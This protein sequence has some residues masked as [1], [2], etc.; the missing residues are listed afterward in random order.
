MHDSRIIA[1]VGGIENV[2]GSNIATP[3]APPS[4]GRT[5]I[6]TP[7]VTPINMRSTLNGV[8]TTANPWNKALSSST[9]SSLD[10][11]QSPPTQPSSE[12]KEFMHE[13]DAELRDRPAVLRRLICL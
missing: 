6:R 10:P 2:S 13:T 11:L 1:E 9:C 4:P 5:P 8:R 12:G 3:F 7:R